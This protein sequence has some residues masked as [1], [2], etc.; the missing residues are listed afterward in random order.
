[1]HGLW[2]Y[3]GGGLG[4]TSITYDLCDRQLD[5]C[6]ST[7]LLNGIDD[8]SVK[9]FWEDQMRQFTKPLAQCWHIVSAP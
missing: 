2:S 1:M 6:A 3:T 5:F 7:F 4:S 8:Y 9:G